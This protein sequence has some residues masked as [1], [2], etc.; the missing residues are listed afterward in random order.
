MCFS[1][2]VSFGA[3]AV[4]STVGI[5]AIKKSTHK[6]QL[7]FAMIPLM[8][9][10]QQFFEGWLWVALQ[11]EKYRASEGIA[12]YG[13]LIF[14]QVI[15][16]VWVP[17]SIYFMEKEKHRK[18]LISISLAAGIFLFVLLGYRMIRYD[19]SAHIEQQ[20]IFYQV[21]HF[22]S[23]NWWSGIFYMLPAVFPF[24]FSSIRHVNYMGILMLL[25]FVVSKIFYLRYMISVWCL[26]AAVLSLYIF[27]ILKKQEYQKV[28]KRV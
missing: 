15:W 2:E 24:I 19:V 16:P 4:I 9:G 18:R 22:Q 23:T 25:F 26:F 10:I 5:I 1:A 11:N 20:H 27:F 6:E 14:A 3:S 7:F 17:L 28:F 13:F 12:T 21:G 8:F